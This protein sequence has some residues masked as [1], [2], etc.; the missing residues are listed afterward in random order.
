[1]ASHTVEVR[2]EGEQ[3]DNGTTWRTISVETDAFDGLA[4]LTPIDARAQ[5]AALI[6]AADRI[7]LPRRYRP[8]DTRRPANAR[9]CQ[10]CH[11]GRDIWSA[12]TRRSP[13]HVA[14]NIRI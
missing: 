2:A 6:D 4:A 7:D 5:A 14:V 10:D 8:R 12:R 1:M 3:H 13:S 11:Q 9:D